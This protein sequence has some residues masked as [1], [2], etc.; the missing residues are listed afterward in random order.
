MF[1]T[2]IHHVNVNLNQIQA[3]RIKDNGLPSLKCNTGADLFVV[4]PLQ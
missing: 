3:K 1:D 2:S 4:L